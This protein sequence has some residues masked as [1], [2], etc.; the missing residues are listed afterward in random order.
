M[1][2]PTVTPTSESMDS[3]MKAMTANL[4]A[5]AQQISNI[6]Q[7]TQQAEVNANRAILPQQNQLQLDSM[8]QFLPQYT[9]LDNANAL[10]RAVG[11]VQ[12]DAAALEAAKSGGL[13]D[14]ALE[15]QRKADPEYF[16][17]RAALGNKLQDIAKFDPNHL[18]GSELEQTRRGL[19]ETAMG[20]PNLGG[21]LQA[22]ATFGNALAKRRG[23]N[24]SYIQTI[25]SSLPML[26]T[27]F[28]PYQ[29]ATG[30]NSGPSQ[31][32]QGNMGYNMGIGQTA[33]NMGSNV[34]NTASAFQRQAAQNEFAKP[35]GLDQ[36]GQ[37]MGLAGK[38]VGGI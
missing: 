16:A 23:E 1:S 27:S 24:Q 13:I 28:D 3:V 36:A 17:N 11:T 21:A 7:P 32:A 25:A 4:P 34:F 2:S 5:Y 33:N 29:V 18:S 31:A 37:V 6:I 15:L 30:K 8:R 35:T 20:A 12:S 9:A 26:K 14:R 22:A 38:L 10:A 19:S